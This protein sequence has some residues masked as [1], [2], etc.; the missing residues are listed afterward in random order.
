MSPT[1]R[2][3]DGAEPMPTSVRVAVI[4]QATLAGLLLLNATLT[5][6][7]RE[8]VADAIV[9]A[10]N[11]SR[12]EAESFVVVWLMPYAVIG[13]I[14]AASAWFVARRQPW[15]RW[16]GLTASAMLAALT[17]VSMASAGGAGIASLLVLVLS[18]AAVTSLVARATAAWVPRLRA[19][20]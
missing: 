10:G 14:L 1:S 6:F 7:G 3:T 19:D 17:L 16:T 8:G 13:L 15:A 2:P 20:A 5:W 18:V 4:V 11:L 12:E 9:E